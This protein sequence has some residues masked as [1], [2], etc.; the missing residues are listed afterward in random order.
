MVY[1]PLSVRIALRNYKAIEARYNRNVKGQG[2]TIRREREMGTYG[3]EQPDNRTPVA[4][5][6]H[7]G[8]RQAY[9]KE[10]SERRVL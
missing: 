10:C 3:H 7:E 1:H 9:V 4:T 5:R 6:W 8:L 2:W